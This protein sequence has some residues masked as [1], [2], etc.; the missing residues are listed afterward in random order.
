[1]GMMREQDITSLV[2]IMA[3]GMVMGMER[4]IS[5]FFIPFRIRPVN[6][7]CITRNSL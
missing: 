6:Q 4:L 5:L 7:G 3:M 1:M 2:F